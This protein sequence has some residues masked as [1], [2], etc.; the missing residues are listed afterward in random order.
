MGARFKYHSLRIDHGQGIM[1]CWWCDSD[2]IWG[3]DVDLEEGM[4][5][6]PEF[7]VM[8]NL[9]CPRCESQVE[10]LKKRDAYD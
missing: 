4:S 9:S 3:S 8:T 7:S 10:V 6:Y 5:G 1:R 2:L